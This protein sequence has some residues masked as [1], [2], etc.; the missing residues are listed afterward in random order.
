MDEPT[1]RLADYVQAYNVNLSQMSRATGINYSLLYDSLANA[2]RM[3]PLRAGELEV[4]CRYLGVS[5]MEF[6]R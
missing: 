5:P 3:R 6:L 1:K 4:I 2:S